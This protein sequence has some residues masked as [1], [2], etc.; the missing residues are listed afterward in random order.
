MASGGARQTGFSKRAQFSAFAGYVVAGLG[1]LLGAALLL[2]GLFRPDLFR[3]APAHSTDVVAPVGEA[4]AV[5]R[6]GT[7]SLMDNIAG[8]FNAGSKNARLMRENKV[9][10]VKLAEARGIEEENRRL[11]ALLGMGDGSVEPVARAR[12][13]GSTAASTRLIAYL[14]AGSRD[15]VTR[16]MPVRSPLGL[17]G[18]V[19]AVG[20]SSSRVLLL[21]DS[22]SM[23]PVRRAGD[24]TVAFAEGRADGTV[25]IRLINLG[26]NPLK[27]GDVFVTSGAG[28]L[29]RPNIAVAVATEITRDGAM[30]RLLSSPAAT[31][32]VTVEPIWQPEARAE[33]ELGDVAVGTAIESTDNSGEA[34]ASAE[35]E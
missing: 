21:S 35:S 3:D 24:N 18:R 14:S 15:G 2:I 28:G 22:E 23:V 32:F 33:I 26:I 20:S 31:E 25:R 12:L 11:K 4:G 34:T 6:S 1:A 5:A 17:V 19:L 30:A 13:I 10:R 16:G 8:Y 7:Q 29:F 27:V 9:A